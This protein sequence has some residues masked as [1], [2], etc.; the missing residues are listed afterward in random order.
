[1]FSFSLLRV[2]YIM[3]Y[4]FIYSSLVSRFLSYFQHFPSQTVDKA[5]DSEESRE[6]HDQLEEDLCQLWD[7][8][9]DTDV[10]KILHEYKLVTIVIGVIQKS[11]QARITVS[12]EKHFAIYFILYMHIVHVCIENKGMLTK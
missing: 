1:M 2:R 10:M 6:G 3:K 12:Y 4:F 5:D 9:L 7:L 8:S 11:K